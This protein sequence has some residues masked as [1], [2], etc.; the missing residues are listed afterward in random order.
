MDYNQSMVRVWGLPINWHNYN[1]QRIHKHT[2][3]LNTI[4][5]KTWAA[6]SE[7]LEGSNILY[8][9]GASNY[10]KDNTY[11][12]GVIAVF[13]KELTT[14]YGFSLVDG[15]YLWATESENYLDLYGSGANAEHT[16]YF[17]YGKLYSV[18]LAGIMYA[19]DLSNWQH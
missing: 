9:T 6:P 16:W 14:H 4:F 11:G 1:S 19:Y 3:N 17:A 15:S 7:W 2:I 18:G 8:Y 5:D 12:N 13:D 10:V